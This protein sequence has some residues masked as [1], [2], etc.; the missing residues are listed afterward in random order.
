MTIEERMTNLELLVDSLVTTMNNQKF[1]TD[2]DIAGCRHT[3]S[4]L[5]N[6]I[7]NITPYEATEK[8]SAG[9]TEVTFVGVPEGITMTTTVM[10]LEGRSITHNVTRDEDIVHVMFEPLEYAA[11]VYVL[12]K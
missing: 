10:D 6:Q 4:N 11:D 8:A 2:A 1:Y 9:D 12:V 7:D 3:E 5:G